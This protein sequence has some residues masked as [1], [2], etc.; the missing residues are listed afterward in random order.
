[1]REARTCVEDFALIP[2]ATWFALEPVTHIVTV[3]AFN[4]KWRTC[5]K[6]AGIT[7]KAHGLRDLKRWEP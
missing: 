4:I 3:D 7:N 1:M 6:D 5:A 2:L